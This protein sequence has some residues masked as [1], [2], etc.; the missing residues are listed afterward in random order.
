MRLQHL[1]LR[2]QPVL[3]LYK[4]K[5]VRLTAAKNIGCNGRKETRWKH[6][7]KAL[8]NA[9]LVIL[10]QLV[11]AVLLT[12]GVVVSCTMLGEIGHKNDDGTFVIEFDDGDRDPAGSQ[13]TRL[14]LHQPLGA[15]CVGHAGLAAPCVG[16]RLS[17]DHF[18]TLDPS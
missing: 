5:E 16:W 10:E 7:L 11:F 15:L 8:L 14:Q 4:A 9:I 17:S 13:P 18:E 2:L 12:L 6:C 1:C 3:L